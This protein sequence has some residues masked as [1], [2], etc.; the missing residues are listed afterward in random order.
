MKGST[1]EPW[2]LD[3][4]DGRRGW[5]ITTLQRLLAALSANGEEARI[6]GGAVRNALMGQPVADIDIATTNLP[7]ETIARAEAAGFRTVPTGK[8][9]GTITVVAHH[10]PF[11][12]TTLRDDVETDGRAR[13]GCIRQGTGSAMPS[14]A[15]LPSTRSTHRPTDR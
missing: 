6:A 14:G 1:V 7:D 8:D 2:P 10:Q 15:T 4:R 5:R 11:E 12:V 3:Q 13:Q 9:H